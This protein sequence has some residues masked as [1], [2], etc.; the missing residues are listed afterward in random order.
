MGKVRGRP[1][2]PG[3]SCGHGRPKG[4]KN[5]VTLL[6]QQLL[7][8]Y[9]ESITR[10]VMIQALQGDRPSQRLCMERAC[11]PVRDAP[12]RMHLGPTKTAAQVDVGMQRVLRAVAHGTITPAHGEIL[13]KIWS[14]EST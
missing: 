10:K 2:Q 14:P 12:V 3:N 5:K 13:I 11:A 8:Q 7:G 4:S 6:V 9:A 1:F